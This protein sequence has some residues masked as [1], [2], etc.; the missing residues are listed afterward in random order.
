VQASAIGSGAF[1][2]LVSQRTGIINQ[3]RAF[4]LERG[5]AVRQGPRFLRTE[6]PLTR[7]GPLKVRRSRA[8][9]RRPDRNELD[10]GA[11]RCRAPAPSRS[12]AISLRKSPEP[13][14]QGWPSWQ[15][16]PRQP[17]ASRDVSNAR[18]ARSPPAQRTSCTTAHRRLE[19][20]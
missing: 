9:I 14:A 5:I 13:F 7:A 8:G 12:E 18:D 15:A 17:A 4:L 11:A 1:E 16:P 19:F 6:L 2:R 3:I 10:R 20:S